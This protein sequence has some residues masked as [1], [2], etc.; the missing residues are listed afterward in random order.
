MNLRERRYTVYL[1]TGNNGG[2]NIMTQEKLREIAA[3]L[4]IVAEEIDGGYEFGFD[5][6]SIEKL[7]TTLEQ[8]AEELSP[9]V[10][11]KSESTDEG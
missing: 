2:E 3:G 5:D 7:I 8:F 9:G 11:L 6:E 4:L 10:N 1:S